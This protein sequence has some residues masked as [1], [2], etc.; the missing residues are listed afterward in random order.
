MSVPDRSDKL[1]VK[2][3]EGTPRDVARKI[4]L[5]GHER[6]YLA[7]H[8][9]HEMMDLVDRVFAPEAPKV[10][11]WTLETVPYGAPLRHKKAGYVGIIT[12]ANTG[13]LFVASTPVSYANA[14]EFWEQLSGAPCGTLKEQPSEW[15]KYAREDSTIWRFKSEEAG[16]IWDGDEP[17]W[18]PSINAWSHVANRQIPA[19]E[20]EALIEKARASK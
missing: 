19:S 10:E 18:T 5:R 16:E 2:P 15:P 11:P 4:V 9:L 8:A 14:L 3:E 6:G 17:T 7:S 12:G 1:I 13:E 20:A